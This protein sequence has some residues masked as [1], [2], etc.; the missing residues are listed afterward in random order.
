MPVPAYAAGSAASAG[1]YAAPIP[2]YDQAGN[3][4]VVTVPIPGG[5]EVRIEGPDL[6]PDAP[7]APIETWGEYAQTPNTVMPSPMGP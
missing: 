5:G 1:E 2:N 4:S 3:G 6:P 7:L